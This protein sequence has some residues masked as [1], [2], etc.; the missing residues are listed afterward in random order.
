MEGN[1]QAKVH[2]IKTYAEAI[3]FKQGQ[4]YEHQ[5]LL[6]TIKQT[7][8]FQTSASKIRSL[9]SFITNL[10]AEFTSFFALLLCAPNIVTQK[11]K[12]CQPFRIIPYHFQN[13]VNFF[14]LEKR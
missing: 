8:I 5:S 7:K 2:H 6:K 14:H 12:L 4:H 10:H 9:L 1:I 11:I 13:V 3:A